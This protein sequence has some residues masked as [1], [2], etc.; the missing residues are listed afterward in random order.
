MFNGIK[1]VGYYTDKSLDVNQNAA[2][3]AQ[4]QYVLAPTILDL[5]NLNHEYI[6]LDCSAEDIAFEKIKEIH[7]IPFKKR[8][9][10]ILA[11]RLPSDLT[12]AQKSFP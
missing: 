7:A 2:E 5:N 3:F 10:L 9:G 4:A 6:L 1:Y 8:L 12:E 11:K